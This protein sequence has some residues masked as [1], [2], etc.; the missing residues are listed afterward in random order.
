MP[1]HR[2]RS[3]ESF[4][5]SSTGRHDTPAVSLTEAAALGRALRTA[6]Q[7][8]PDADKAKLRACA[9]EI[10]ASVRDIRR[11]QAKGNETRDET[12]ALALLVKDARI[13]LAGAH[14]D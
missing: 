10:N 4:L 14:R 9:V 7:A 6:E 8:A 1:A 2:P 12:F 5:A 11:K 3:L 13:L